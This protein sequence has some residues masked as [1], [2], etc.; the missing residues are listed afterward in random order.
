MGGLIQPLC[1]DVSQ[2]FPPSS[3]AYGLVFSLFVLGGGQDG[4]ASCSDP[5]TPAADLS[6]TTQP[7][8]WS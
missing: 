3:V 4:P 2:V 8:A 7:P 6:P 5:L 1:H